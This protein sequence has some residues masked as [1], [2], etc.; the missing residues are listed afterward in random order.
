MNR[1]LLLARTFFS[2]F[3]ESELMPPGLPQ[4]QLV[5]WSM[6]GLA[7]PG[8]LLP[9]KFALSFARIDADAASVTRALLTFRL[10]FITLTM[11]AIGLVAIVIWDGM[12]PDR[13][14]ARILTP[15]PVPGTTLIGARLL[16]LAALCGI[17]VVG[18]NVIPSVIYGPMVAAFGGASH[19]LLGL[20]G[21]F[22]STTLAGFFVFS[23][24]IALQGIVLNL[25]GRRASER[26]SVLLQILFVVMLLQM[27]F[28]MPRL[29]GMIA[30]DLNSGWL[31]AMPS[32]WFLGLYDVIGGR[33]VAG[34]PKLAFAAVG[35]TA[36]SVA[37]AV[38]LFVSTHQ[39]LTRLAIESREVG[40]RS[41][42]V[43]RAVGALTR[44]VCRR[45][46]SQATF[47]F[48]LRTLVRSRSHRL[49]VSAYLG[50]GLALVASAIVPLAIRRGFS[51][52]TVP[53]FELLSA[54][55]VI[56]FLTTVGM[57]VAFAIPVEPRANWAIRIAEPADRR[58]AM[59]GVR[60]ALALGG[61]APA[62]LFAAVSAGLLWEPRAA[63]L[64][65]F[66][67][68]VMGMLLVDILLINL[69]KL[70]FTC[71]YYPGKAKFGRLWP[72]YLTAFG[73][74]A[75]TTARFE[76]EVLNQSMLRPFVI[77][78]VLVAAAIALLSVLRN[79]YL[80][81]LQGFRFEE[82]D[83]DSIFRGF[84]LSEGF[85]ARSRTET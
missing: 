64:H 3:F 41:R 25:G 18:V 58:A 51:G 22:V 11:T 60:A 59:A 82:E 83:P 13:R 84:E 70:P 52:F 69:P 68:A 79:R 42:L 37:A 34:A 53:N 24:L 7:T 43:E 4:A 40:R 9:M 75:F 32:V 76:L 28:F 5:I 21:H 10:L 35:A 66:V 63:M 67:C 23:S 8:L 26:L 30:A 81:S 45:P 50:I 14:D 54:P 61:V 85:A 2:R 73:T 62:V 20:L 27:I 16:A 39:R 36:I 65:V 31:R 47:E 46:V 38:L 17:F 72:L 48:T 80:E 12:F 78:S 55:L 6:V 33:P 19:M 77:L 74:Y 56:T 71:T 1:T 29:G 57:R 44:I 49:L 15:L